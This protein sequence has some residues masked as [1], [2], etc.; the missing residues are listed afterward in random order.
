MWVVSHMYPPRSIIQPKQ[1]KAQ[2]KQ[3]NMIYTI[4]CL[5]LM[6]SDFESKAEKL[7]SSAE[8]RIRTLEVCDTKSPADWIHYMIHSQHRANMKNDLQNINL[9]LIQMHHFVQVWNHSILNKSTLYIIHK[10]MS[11][12]IHS[13]KIFTSL[14]QSYQIMRESSE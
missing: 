1:N 7:S 4:C 10:L 9:K 11:V 3:F 6:G 12:Y 2:Q 8:S 5:L 14:S 13:C